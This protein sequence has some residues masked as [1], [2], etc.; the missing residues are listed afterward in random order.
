MSST[1]SHSTTTLISGAVLLKG[2]MLEPVS[3]QAVVI[4]NECI[5]RLATEHEI[6]VG[7]DWRVIYAGGKTVLQGL[8]DAHIH[9]FGSRRP[10][11]KMWGI[12]TPSLNCPRAVSVCWKWPAHGF[13]TM[14][15]P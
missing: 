2:S 3:G 15:E 4:K 14:S 1:T 11:P 6:A 8:I 13:T 10:D 5:V 12:E 9:F 7:K